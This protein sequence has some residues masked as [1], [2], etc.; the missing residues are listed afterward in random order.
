MTSDSD[1]TGQPDDPGASEGGELRRRLEKLT[2]INAALMGRV[3]RSMDA[4]GNAYALFQTAIG[5]DS[6][7]RARTAEVKSALGQGSTFTV[8]LPLALPAA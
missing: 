5:L 3:E 4:Q 6:E 2:K 7:I 8:V 1:G